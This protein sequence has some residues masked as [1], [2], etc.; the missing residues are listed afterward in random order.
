MPARAPALY[1]S[2]LRQLAGLGERLRTARLRRALSAETVCARADISRPT[3]S[4][5]EQ[6]DAS[7]T[8]GN[9]L[10]VLRVLGLDGDLAA[11]AADDVVGR[12]LQDAGLARKA[13][14][15]RRKQAAIA[16]PQPGL[17]DGDTQPSGNDAAAAL[18]AP[19]SS[20]P[21]AA[22]LHSVKPS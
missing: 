7:V 2:A 4:K 20:S 13:R 9:Y 17:A 11:L 18:A 19:P 3:L 12:R 16:A 1:P 8:L 10:Q 15:P 5:I 21:A 14:A 6:G 22:D